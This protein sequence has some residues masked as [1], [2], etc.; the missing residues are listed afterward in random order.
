VRQNDGGWIGSPI[1]ELPWKKQINAVTKDVERIY[2][3]DRGKPMCLNSTGMILRA[4][5]NHPRYRKCKEARKAAQLLK[6]HFFMENNYSS[7]KHKDH[8]LFFQFPYWWNSLISALDSI[9]Q[10]YTDRNDEDIQKAVRWIIAN[11]E[12]SGLWKMSYSSIHKN[13]I[14]EK[15]KETQ[16]WITY[17]ICKIIKRLYS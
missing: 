7:Y 3:W 14:T 9:S 12:K 2:E 16:L 10:I 5:A 1:Y 17:A 6:N 8:W 4:F 11:Q 15:T 13:T